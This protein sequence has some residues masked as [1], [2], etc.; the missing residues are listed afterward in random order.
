MIIVPFFKENSLKLFSKKK[1]FAL[2]RQ[3]MSIIKKGEHL[4]DNGLARLNLIKEK[5]H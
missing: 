5:M 4:T 2:F 3:I 1:D